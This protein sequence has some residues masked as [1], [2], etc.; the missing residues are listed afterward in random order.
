M[1]GKYTP[2]Q[3]YLEGL[4][5]N[6][7]EVTLSFEGTERILGD[8]LPRSA[9][10]HRAWWANEQ[11]G[12]HTHAHAWMDAGWKVESVDQQRCIVRFRRA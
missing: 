10:D 12:M 8:K 7:A 1:A 6:Q 5:S 3:D 11:D 4:P 2:L 9:H